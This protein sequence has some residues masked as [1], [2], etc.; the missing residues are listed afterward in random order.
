MK[1]TDLYQPVKQ[2]FEDFGFKINSE[3]GGIDVTAVKDDEMTVVELKT[4]LNLK[5]IIQAAKR[6]RLTSHVYV[7][8]PRPNWKKL[9]RKDWK[10]KLY[11]LRRLELGLIYVKFNH[12]NAVATIEFEPKE[13]DRVKSIRLGARKRKEIKKEINGRHGDY[14]LGGSNKT[15]LVTAYKENAIYIAAL[16]EKNGVMSTKAL[17]EAGSGEKT[18]TILNNNFYGWYDRVAR[19]RYAL[20]LKGKNELDQYRIIADKLLDN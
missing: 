15:K 10:D 1:E 13:F 12:Q 2:L 4:S 3:V 18:T 6:Q 19:G 11:L 20:S 5:L 7:A 16:L 8:I 14:N 17:R 9:H